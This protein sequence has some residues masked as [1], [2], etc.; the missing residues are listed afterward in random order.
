RDS[1]TKPGRA[2]AFA[3]QKGVGDPAA[4][5]SVAVLEEKAG[6]FEE[7]LLARYREIDQHVAR[8]Q[9]PGDSVHLHSPHMRKRLPHGAGS[10]RRSSHYSQC[11]KGKPCDVAPQQRPCAR[12]STSKRAPGGAPGVE[13][14]AVSDRWLHKWMT[15]QSF[16]AVLG[17]F[18]L[19][20]QDLS[21]QLVDQ[22]VY[23]R[24]QVTIGA[25]RKE[26]L[27]PDMQ[28]DLGLLDQLVD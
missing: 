13:T 15:L 8:C 20:F 5:D 4:L 28:A 1:V 25:F 19:Q 11:R 27:A 21:I 10:K 26:V 3:R 16:M 17:P 7:S 23:R 22:R 2:Q 12:K 6:L 14:A 9:Q 24:V 18:P